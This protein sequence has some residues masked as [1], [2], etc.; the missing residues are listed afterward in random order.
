M[1]LDDVDVF[2]TQS[3]AMRW[4]LAE[5]ARAAPLDLAVLI[6]GEAG[7]GK[8][9]LARWIH[10]HSRRAD[11]PFVRVD[12]G[13]FQDM[14]L[15]DL[16]DPLHEPFK[17]A[18]RNIFDAA[19]GGTLFLDN[20]GDLSKAVQLE[21]V[22]VIEEP[23]PHD[24]GD[25]RHMD[26][27][28][29]VATT[30]DLKDEVAQR[31]FRPD[32]FYGLSSGTLHIPPL[33]ER[34]RDLWILACALL[35]R[36]AAHRNRSIGGF[37][38]HAMVHVLSYD[39]PGNVR[40]LEQAI[41]H[42]CARAT[43]SEIELG[44]LPEAVQ[45]DCGSTR[46][47]GAGPSGTVRPLNSLWHA[48]LEPDTDPRL[49]VQSAL[50]T[51]GPSEDVVTPACQVYEAALFAILTALSTC[52]GDFRFLQALTGLAPDHLS[53]HL[54]RLEE[55]GLITVDTPIAGT[56]PH[57]W[58]AITAAGRGVCQAHRQR[59]D[60]SATAA[61]S[62]RAW[63]GAAIRTDDLSGTAGHASASPPPSAAD[64][65]GDIRRLSDAAERLIDA[66]LARQSGHRRRAAEELGIS[67]ATLNR[68]LRRRRGH[69]PPGDRGV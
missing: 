1:S 54:Q 52:Q 48:R 15:G 30:R 5:A 37:K 17:G 11:G 38:T 34:P 27:R 66:A 14:P 65:F 19:A 6:T 63:A 44:D 20:I 9:R 23:A 46:S 16:V 35:D 60:T 47:D 41:E 67:L 28:L 42:A 39:W 3:P 32:L 62:R 57:G 4:V 22:R 2:D 18:V 49:D 7:V 69:T 56:Y 43:G 12:C 26:G 25:V 53:G 8:E 59:P 13:V 21:L 40:E 33:R 24:V 36:A 64:S 68:K 50:A 58:M 51:P 29:I 55:E 10:A 61:T 45:H 31:R